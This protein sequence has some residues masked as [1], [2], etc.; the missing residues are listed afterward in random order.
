[1][2]NPTSFHSATEVL[3]FGLTARS[4]ENDA[5]CM[6]AVPAVAVADALVVVVAGA[7]CIAIV[8]LGEIGH[9]MPLI[10]LAAALEK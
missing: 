2:E 7:G 6:V 9:S 10:R 3:N 4:P 5:L 1:M 8:T